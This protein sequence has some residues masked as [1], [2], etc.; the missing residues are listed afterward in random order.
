MGLL[1]FNAIEDYISKTPLSGVPGKESVF[2]IVSWGDLTLNLE[3]NVHTLDLGF[4]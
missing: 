3:R 1:M 2:G 4:N